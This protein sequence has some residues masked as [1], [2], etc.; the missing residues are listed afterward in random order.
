VCLCHQG[1]FKAYI[2]GLHGGANGKAEAAKITSRPVKARTIL[3]AP[4]GFILS[5]EDRA[6][7]D[8]YLDS[9]EHMSRKELKASA[10]MIKEEYKWA[11]IATGN[12][13]RLHLNLKKWL[14]MMYPLAGQ[15]STASASGASGK[16][17]STSGE[18]PAG[19]RKRKS[20]PEL[21]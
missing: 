11:N 5:D 14:D 19:T 8:A 18:D 10:T 13:A 16:S 9:W 7:R 21:P 3:T 2:P 17:S 1:K 15:S 12:P 6:K 20:P 4:K